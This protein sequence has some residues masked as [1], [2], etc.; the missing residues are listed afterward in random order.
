LTSI[1]KQKK[2]SMFSRDYKY[3][4][5]I[6]PQ[7][8]IHEFLDFVEHAA[9][10]IENY[11][12]SEPT[13]HH[14][15]VLDSMMKNGWVRGRFADSIYL[16]LDINSNFNV[17]A[18]YGIIKDALDCDINVMVHISNE[19]VVWIKNSVDLGDVMRTLRKGEQ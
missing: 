11:L 10:A 9:Y 16:I 13:I 3:K 7:G 19:D 6:S 15:D 18:I 1:S 17:D 5:W 14:P 4:W 8:Q 2:I 12:V